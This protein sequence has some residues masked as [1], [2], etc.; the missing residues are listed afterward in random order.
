MGLEKGEGRGEKRGE[1]IKLILPDRS[2]DCLCGIGTPKWQDYAF[3]SKAVSRTLSLGNRA[4]IRGDAGTREPP[5]LP[6]ASPGTTPGTSEALASKARRQELRFRMEVSCL[7]SR[8]PGSAEGSRTWRAPAAAAAASPRFRPP[9][10]A[11]RAA[12]RGAQPLG[13]IRIFS[14]SVLPPG[15]IADDLII[16][17]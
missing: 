16:L 10:R 5:R 15:Q 11:S 13:L 14:P 3:G 2:G 12:P 9:A 6:P 7:E 1:G 4:G 8:A 17:K